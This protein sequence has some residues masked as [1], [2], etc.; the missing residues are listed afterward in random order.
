MQQIDVRAE[1]CVKYCDRMSK[2][3]ENRVGS[4]AESAEQG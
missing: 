3:L 1:S 4:D 2:V